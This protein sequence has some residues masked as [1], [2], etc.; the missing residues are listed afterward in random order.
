M[1][2]DFVIIPRAH[3][4]KTLP[5]HFREVAAGAKRAEIRKD[6][7]GF[8]RDDWLILRE[9]DG[10]GYSGRFVIARVTHVLRGPEF[11]DGASGLAPGFVS[12]SIDIIATDGRPSE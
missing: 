5:V 9:W 10:A 12:L 1:A 11:V 3:D 2:T 4:L 6:D 8:S 7:R